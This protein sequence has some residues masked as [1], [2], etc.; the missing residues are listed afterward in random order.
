[1]MRTKAGR[2]VGFPT[3]GLTCASCFFFFSVAMVVV[4]VAVHHSLPEGNAD[5]VTLYI[6]SALFRL[7]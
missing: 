7:D 1:M 2:P 6:M 5:T 4:V 3:R